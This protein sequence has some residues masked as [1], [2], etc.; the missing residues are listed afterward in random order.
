MPEHCIDCPLFGD[1]MCPLLG[2]V[3]G[4]SD[5]CGPYKLYA[6]ERTEHTISLNLISE[7]ITERH[8]ARQGGN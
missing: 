1:K 3:S 5:V 7:R 6:R 4:W 2:K 8:R